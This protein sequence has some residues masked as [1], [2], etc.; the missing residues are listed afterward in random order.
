MEG[1][2]PSTRL[3]VSNGDQCLSGENG[4][5]RPGIAGSL[6]TDVEPD[7]GEDDDIVAA[8]C[9][10]GKRERR[11]SSRKARKSVNCEPL[12][13]VHR[14]SRVGKAQGRVHAN[15]LL[16]KLVAATSLSSSLGLVSHCKLP[17][18]VRTGSGTLQS[19]LQGA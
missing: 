12:P 1:G 13:E 2:A 19:G 16:L 5:P 10:K 14:D 15:S 11:R 6:P 4:S 8:R 17:L 18:S 3:A 7:A 9:C